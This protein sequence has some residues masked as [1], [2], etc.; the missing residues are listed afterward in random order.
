MGSAEDPEGVEVSV[1]VAVA[2]EVVAVDTSVASSSSIIKSRSELAKVAL[3][4]EDDDD[5]DAAATEVPAEVDDGIDEPAIAAR[6]VVDVE[7]VA[8]DAEDAIEVDAEERVED[9][10]A[11]AAD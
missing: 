1:G 4:L 11:L 6:L 7:A 9:V 8:E 2:D 5:E 3:K 10:V